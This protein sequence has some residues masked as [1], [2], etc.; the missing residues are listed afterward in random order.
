MGSSTVWALRRLKSLHSVE[1]SPEWTLAVNRTVESTWR[2]VNRTLAPERWVGVHERCVAVAAGGCSSG[3]A[4]SA[5]DD[6]TAYV[7][8]PRQLRE[9]PAAFDYVLVDGRARV[10]CIKEALASPSLVAE[11]AHG[12]LVLD[13]A[14]RT[15][16]AEGIAA[17]PAAWLCYGFRNTLDETIVW[18]ACA[19]DEPHCRRARRALR[20]L[21]GAQRLR[22]SHKCTRHLELG[23]G[24]GDG[25]GNTVGEEEEADEQEKVEVGLALPQT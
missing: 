11:A 21:H 12:L 25:G 10:A 18:M 17:V 22:R 5:T 1:S 4:S 6:Y 8:A 3:Q 15:R 7:S 16:Y 20:R 24:G 2:H 23:G 13:N 9:R 14:E 19:P